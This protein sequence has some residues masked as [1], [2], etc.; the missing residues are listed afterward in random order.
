MRFLRGHHVNG[1]LTVE[2]DKEREKA[3]I[4]AVCEDRTRKVEMCSAGKPR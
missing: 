2:L 1:A 3:L 4:L